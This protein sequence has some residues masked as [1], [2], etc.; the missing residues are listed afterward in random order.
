VLTDILEFIM[1]G[2]S[3]SSPLAKS[4]FVRMLERNNKSQFADRVFPSTIPLRPQA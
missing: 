1:L 2:P 4:A 3:V